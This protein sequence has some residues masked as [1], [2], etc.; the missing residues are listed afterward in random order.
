MDENKTYT[1]GG[2]TARIVV[3]PNTALYK[4]SMDCQTPAEI[5]GLYTKKEWAEIALLNFI[6]TKELKEEEKEAK[7]IAEEARKMNRPSYRMAKE[8]EAR[9][10][11]K[12]DGTS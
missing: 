4:I 2:K 8:K 10:K 11:A 5:S 1:V 3:A 6:A 12:L 9:E 7:E